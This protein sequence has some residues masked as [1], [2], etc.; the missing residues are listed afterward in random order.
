MTFKGN[1]FAI[2]GFAPVPSVRRQS[3]LRADPA[4]GGRL[5]LPPVAG[6]EPVDVYH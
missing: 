5:A 6:G 4:V 1:E 3:R 2:H